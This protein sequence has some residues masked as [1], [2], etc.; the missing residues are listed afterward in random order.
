VEIVVDRGFQG[1]VSASQ[2]EAICRE[3]EKVFASAE[4]E[5]GALLGI[6]R[7]HALLNQH[8]PLQGG[9]ANELP[10]RPVRV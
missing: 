8:F 6:E 9:N 4:F 1:R 7:I 10:N 3:M 2:W 5:A